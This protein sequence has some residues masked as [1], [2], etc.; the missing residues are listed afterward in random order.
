MQFLIFLAFLVLI[1]VFLLRFPA[2]AYMIGLAVFFN[3]G[4]FLSKYTFGFPGFSSSSIGLLIAVIAGFRTVNF[5]FKELSKD[6]K[7]LLKILI[8]FSIYQ[9]I[10]TIIINLNTYQPFQILNLLDYHKWRI[11]GVYFA[12][13]TYFIVQKYSKTIYKIVIYVCLI[14]LGLYYLNLFTPLHFMEIVQVEREFVTGAIR[15]SM[16]NYGYIYFSIVFGFIVYFLKLKIK[17]RNAVFL[18]AILM[19]ITVFITLTRGT[20]IYTIGSIIITFFILTKY[21]NVPISKTVI[22]GGMAF[23]V[24]LIIIWYTF[25][26][27]LSELFKTYFLTFQEVTGQIPRGTTQSRSEFELLTMGPV[28]LEHFWIGTGYL[29]D[30]FESYGT[31]WELGLADIPVL[32]NLAIY[33]IVGFSLYLIRYFVIH[34]EIKKMLQLH[35]RISIL[36]VLS[37]YDIVLFLWAI[38]A[39]Y[40]SI[41]F[42]FFNFSMDLVYGGVN[43]GFMIGILYGI[44]NKFQKGVINNGEKSVNSRTTY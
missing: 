18:A 2:I 43:V 33:G 10:F 14:T 4:G 38:V 41:F 9:I 11:F 32:G 13:P 8:L 24:A 20:T 29:R 16:V 12:I 44:S 31:E 25:P 21:F 26:N 22:R 1:F 34:K 27:L 28:F 37:A 15:T 3:I 30:Y 17:N 6:L 35:K 39:F 42:T 23:S 36:S 7:F 5:K 40:T 19:I